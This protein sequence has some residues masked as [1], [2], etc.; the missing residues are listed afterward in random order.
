MYEMIVKTF[1]MIVKSFHMI[2][3][4]E[5]Y[6]SIALESKTVCNAFNFDPITNLSAHADAPA[7][8]QRR[9]EYD[10]T[11]YRMS[12]GNKEFIEAQFV[13]TN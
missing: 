2:V 1:E 4:S 12:S 13:T 7:A 10:S 9:S 6:K 8:R 11:S 5:V 3:E